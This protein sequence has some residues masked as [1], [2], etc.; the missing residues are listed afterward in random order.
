M[1]IEDIRNYPLIHTVWIT[2]HIFIV[3]TRVLM[4]IS[5]RYP[6]K[7]GCVSGK[8]KQSLTVITIMAASVISCG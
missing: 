8:P 5:Q 6:M 1:N 4:G 3:K 2:T 7:I